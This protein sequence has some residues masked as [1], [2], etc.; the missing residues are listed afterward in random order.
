MAD[1]KG[2][3]HITDNNDIYEPARNNNFEFLVSNLDGILKAGTDESAIQD[4]DYIR[5]GEEVLR[6]SVESSSVPNF[7]LGVIDVKRGNNT[8]HFAGL[9]TFPSGSLT[10]KD[11]ISI[12]SGYSNP[13][14]VMLAWQSLAYN[15]KTEQIHRAS[16]Y[17]KTCSLIEWTPDYKQVV[18][19]WTLEGCWVSEVSEDN[20]STESEGKRVFTAT[21]V[22]DKAY[23]VR[24]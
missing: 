18:R 1:N 6:V 7:Q 8:A 9:P 21:V 23:P 19:K 4:E 17:K 12:N 10:V 5:N 22:Y 14:D 20:F 13:K 2:T 3:Y 16:N 11:F 24:D 15:V